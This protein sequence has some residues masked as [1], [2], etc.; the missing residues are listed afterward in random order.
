MEGFVKHT[1]SRDDNKSEK[2]RLGGQHEVMMDAMSNQ[3][4]IA[5][6]D[7]SRS[8]LRILDSGT[9]DGRWLL[10][11]HQSVPSTV[12]HEYFGTDIDENLYPVAPPG[13]ICFQN[14]S[15]R[16]AFPAEW[17]QSFD[18]VHQRLVM[19]AASPATVLSVVDRLVGLLKSGGWLQ[20]VEVDTDCLPGNG[21]ALESF[22]SYAQMMSE[23]GNMGPNLAVG[24]GDAMRQA[25]LQEVQQQEYFL[26][27]GLRNG[28]E[29]L[30]QKSMESLCMAVPPLMQGVKMLLPDK[31]DEKEATTLQAAL[32]KE[33]EEEGGTTK[34]LVVYGQKP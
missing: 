28:I 10:D 13:N 14:Q 19:A 20:L 22:L 5:P 6:L 34:I 30:R 26:M 16:E 21:P 9:A 8:S 25:G 33:L 27:H 23:A 24:L 4:V 12:K 32:R 29:N 31:Y 18:L 3:A 1:K 17:Q 15:I 2:E 11:L 7:L